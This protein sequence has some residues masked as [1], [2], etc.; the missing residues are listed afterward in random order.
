MFFFSSAKSLNKIENIQERGIR[1]LYN[2]YATSYEDLLEK[3]GRSTIKVKN[4]KVLCVEIYKTLN[5]LNPSFMMEIFKLR[6]TNRP[7]REQ[8]QLNLEIP[9]PNQIRFGEKS[10]TS[11]GPKIWN[12]LPYHIKSSENWKIFRSL[13][14]NWNGTSCKCNVCK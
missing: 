1:F 6:T 5:E 12:T 11:F 13:L 9:N 7:V 4:I 10:L 2:D 8:Y 14:K 3:S